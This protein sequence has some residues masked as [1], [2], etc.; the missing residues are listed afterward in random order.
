MYVSGIFSISRVFDGAKKERTR[1]FS[2]PL[3]KLRKQQQPQQPQQQQ[4][5]SAGEMEGF[6]YSQSCFES[7][8]LLSS[9]LGDGSGK[10]HLGKEITVGGWVRRFFSSFFSFVFF[11]SFLS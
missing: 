1:A 6:K 5:M 4:K 10:E 3:G 8:V 11:F 7:R 9:L 2:L